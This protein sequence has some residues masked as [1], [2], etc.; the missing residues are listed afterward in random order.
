M[1]VFIVVVVANEMIREQREG[2]GEKGDERGEKGDE[3][4]TFVRWDH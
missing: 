3:R 4:R 1:L 2:R